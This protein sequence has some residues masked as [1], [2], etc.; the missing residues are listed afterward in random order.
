[1]MRARIFTGLTLAALAL[2]A[3][4]KPG[5]RVLF[6]GKYYPTRAKKAGETRQ[7]FVVTVRRADQGIEGARKAGRWEAT[8]YCIKL[9]GD[10]TVDWQPGYDPEGGA[11][12]VEGGNL[13]LRGACVK[14]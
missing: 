4:A 11:A 1:M 8:R 10:S 12:V 7:S 5:D 13:I 3:C 9:V 14:W 2:G 6:D